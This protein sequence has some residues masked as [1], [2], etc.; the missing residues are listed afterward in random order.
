MERYCNGT[1]RERDT[2]TERHG[3][4]NGQSQKRQREV[5]HYHNVQRQVTDTLCS[6]LRSRDGHI[7]TKKAVNKSTITIF[8]DPLPSSMLLLRTPAM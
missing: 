2:K 8:H 5:R 7:L 3:K 6:Y 1:E 4:I